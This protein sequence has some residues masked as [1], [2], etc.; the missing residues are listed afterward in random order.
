MDEDDERRLWL[1]QQLSAA[2]SLVWLPVKVTGGSWPR[3][4][5]YRA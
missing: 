5:E 3:R 2:V 1:S 4:S